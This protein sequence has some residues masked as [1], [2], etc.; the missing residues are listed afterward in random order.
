MRISF[1]ASL[2]RIFCTCK[3]HNLKISGA[4]T[5][6]L[7]YSLS[8]TYSDESQLREMKMKISLY[9]FV[10]EKIKIQSKDVGRCTRR[11]IIEKRLN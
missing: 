8:S 10:K 2:F 9:S 5:L 11:W 7:N 6:E 4:I 3:G 1:S